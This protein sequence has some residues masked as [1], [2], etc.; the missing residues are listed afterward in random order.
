MVNFKI[1]HTLTKTIDMPRIIL[2]CMGSCLLT[3]C[4][5]LCFKCLKCMHVDF[6]VSYIFEV[7]AKAALSAGDQC[8]NVLKL[9][10]AMTSYI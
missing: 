3:Y 2:K 10:C 1:L 4:M 9:P 7:D 6:D 5:Q 8:F